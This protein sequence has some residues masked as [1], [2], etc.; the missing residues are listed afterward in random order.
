MLERFTGCPVSNPVFL[1]LV[2]AQDGRHNGHECTKNADNKDG[3]GLPFAKA[4]KHG[5]AASC[6]DLKKTKLF[7]PPLGMHA[8]LVIPKNLVFDSFGDVIF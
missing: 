2:K 3:P 4:G 1:K 6:H 7:K 8:F 5:N